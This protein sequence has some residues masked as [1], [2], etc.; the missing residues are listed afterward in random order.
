MIR[1][2]ETIKEVINNAIPIEAPTNSIFCLMVTKLLMLVKY[3]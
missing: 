1:I 3:L 2:N